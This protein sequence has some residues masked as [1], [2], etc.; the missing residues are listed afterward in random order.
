MRKLEITRKGVGNYSREELF[1]E[2]TSQLKTIGEMIKANEKETVIS[3]ITDSHAIHFRLP[4]KQTS[5]SVI[6][7]TMHLEAGDCKS[8]AH[9]PENYPLGS[10]AVQEIEKFFNNPFRES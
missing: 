7:G 5:S 6:E 8:I 2:A 10:I 4:S 9:I 1:K 3:E